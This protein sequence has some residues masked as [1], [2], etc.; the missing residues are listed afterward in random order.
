MFVLVLYFEENDNYEYFGQLYCIV[1][2]N[3]KIDW[4]ILSVY[5]NFF[6][7]IYRMV[8]ICFVGWWRGCCG[9]N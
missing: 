7:I 2:C 8:S 9:F 6:Q 3:L 1:F 5:F 4:M